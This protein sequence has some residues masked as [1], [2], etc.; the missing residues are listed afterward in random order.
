MVP[1]MHVPASAALIRS[2]VMR[3][4]SGRMRNVMRRVLILTARLRMLMLLEYAVGSSSPVRTGIRAGVRGL[5]FK[6]LLFRGLML[7]GLM[8]GG[9]M[10]RGLM[11][12]RLM[13]R[14]LMLRRLM[15]RRLMLRRLMLRG[16]MLRRLMLRGLMLRQLMLRGLM[17]RRLMLLSA[18]L[19]DDGSPAVMRTVCYRL[20]VMRWPGTS[21]VDIDPEASLPTNIVGGCS[22]NRDRGTLH[23]LRG[24]GCGRTSLP[25]RK[26]IEDWGH[27]RTHAL[28]SGF[29]ISRT[30][31]AQGLAVCIPRSR[32]AP[33]LIP[34]AYEFPLSRYW[35]EPS[36]LL[37]YGADLPT[38]SQQYH[39]EGTA[40]MHSI[41]CPMFY[42]TDLR[43]T[44]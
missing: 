42:K 14:G 29:Q 36:P 13:L 26:T 34:S 19:A 33:R 30:W 18:L 24:I 11:L 7:R 9:L 43:S 2:D 39:L 8:L 12:R 40:N 21:G 27:T 5:M 25:R 10:L 17:L 6:G 3:R 1:G 35:T 4:R 41:P 32:L 37:G 28:N 31:A 16:L 38:V 15:L 23:F 20:A 44:M 22:S